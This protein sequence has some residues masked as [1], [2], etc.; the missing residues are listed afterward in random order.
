LCDYWSRNVGSFLTTTSHEIR[1]EQCQPC[2]TT[3]MVE[4]SS[5]PSSSLDQE[6]A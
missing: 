6:F 4:L 1:I 5:S 3:V 2:K